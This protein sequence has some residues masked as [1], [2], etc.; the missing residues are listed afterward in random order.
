MFPRNCNTWFV[1][2]MDN[3]FFERNGD[4]SSRLLCIA[5]SV[6]ASITNTWEV[7]DEVFKVEGDGLFFLHIQCG[8]TVSIWM[9]YSKG[10]WI[11]HIF[12]SWCLLFLNQITARLCYY[13]CKNIIYLFRRAYFEFSRTINMIAVLLKLVLVK[14]YI[15]SC[16]GWIKSNQGFLNVSSTTNR[17]SSRKT[18][19]S[20]QPERY[21]REACPTEPVPCLCKAESPAD[22]ICD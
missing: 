1:K 5:D 6:R 7:S 13:T 4:E 21:L 20:G 9:L 2:S 3:P 10:E 14:Y 17:K 8:R 18:R 22:M 12:L 11:K 19:K 16:Q 15:V